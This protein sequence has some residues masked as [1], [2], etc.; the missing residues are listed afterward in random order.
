[1]NMEV[2]LFFLKT[3]DVQLW[4]MNWCCLLSL[5]ETD[6]CGSSFS[7]E[8]K[9]K[10]AIWLQEQTTNPLRKGFTTKEVHKVHGI[11]RESL[12]VSICCIF[13]NSF[14]HIREDQAP[15]YFEGLVVPP[16]HLEGRKLNCLF[17]AQLT[18]QAIR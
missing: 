9:K 13:P 7:F 16:P 18:T 11:G 12:S 4:Q 3:I 15:L 5:H 1:M 14:F 6:D 8:K 2:F 10:A 17:T